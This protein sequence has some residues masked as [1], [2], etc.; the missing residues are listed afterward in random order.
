TL[1]ATHPSLSQNEIRLAAYMKLNMTHKDIG[2]ILNVQPESVRK[3]KTRMR[4]KM[5]L[6]S[7]KDITNYL[8]KF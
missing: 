3:A 7:D 6:A 5:G 8:R 1:H 4:Q 2:R